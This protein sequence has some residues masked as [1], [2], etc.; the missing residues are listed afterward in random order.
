MLALVLILVL[1]GCRVVIMQVSTTYYVLLSVSMVAITHIMR[2]GDAL[3]P[4]LFRSTSSTIIISNIIATSSFVRSLDL[5]YPQQRQW[6]WLGDSSCVSSSCSTTTTGQKRR[7]SHRTANNMHP[8][9]RVGRQAG[10]Q[11]GTGVACRIRTFDEIC[12]V[13]VNT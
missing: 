13:T 12:M 3:S 10:R 11:T 7:E 5:Q 1:P 2:V 6:W 8:L 4:C 9:W